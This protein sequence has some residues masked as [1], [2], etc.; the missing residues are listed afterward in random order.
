M[1]A[2][3]VSVAVATALLNDMVS[4]FPRSITLEARQDIDF[5]LVDS[6]PD[7]TMLPDDSTNYNP[8]AAISAVVA[9][10]SSN[11]L[12]Q[13]RR[14]VQRRSIVTNTYPGYTDNIAV[15]NAAINAPSD[16][17]GFVGYEAIMT[18]DSADC[19][20]RTRTWASSCSPTERSILSYA[21]PL[22]RKA[23]LLY[24]CSFC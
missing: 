20:H 15:G 6:S 2:A 3:F 13:Q 21:Q 11:P 12:P 4:A 7:P 10:I 16:C 8:T 19:I 14:S 23:H 1:K 22:A 24:F 9:E 5:D 18:F 17:N